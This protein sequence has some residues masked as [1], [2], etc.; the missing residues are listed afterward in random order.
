MGISTVEVLVAG[1]IGIII[2]MS[3]IDM[4][5]TNMRMAKQSEVLSG[6][7]QDQ[8][9]LDG[10]ISGND[11]CT[12]TLGGV[13]IAALNAKD[14]KDPTKFK[15]D[16]IE[17]NS[18]KDATGKE[19]ICKHDSADPKNC[20][21][22]PGYVYEKLLL[23]HGRDP[24]DPSKQTAD[25]VLE[26]QL[27]PND[28]K[29]I[30]PRGRQYIISANADATGKVVS[31]QFQRSKELDAY[32]QS[33]TQAVTSTVRAQAMKESCESMGGALDANKGVCMYN[34]KPISE[35]LALASKDNTQT[36]QALTDAIS[37]VDATA[38]NA[39]A[40][41]Q[42]NSGKTVDLPPKYTAGSCKASC[43][44]P[45][46]VCTFGNHGQVGM[47][48]NGTQTCI[49]NLSLGEGVIVAD[50]TTTALSGEC[51]LDVNVAKVSADPRVREG[52][53]CGMVTERKTCVAKCT[54]VVENICVSN[55][56][57]K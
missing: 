56:P 22:M 48:N 52:F 31:C 29:M 50:A 1:S 8:M 39:L 46:T 25:I 51:K 7:K 49:V 15:D 36:V 38:T 32:A 26:L 18:L 20:S 44:I 30:R 17:V 23:K 42:A 34:G 43:T 6:I 33:I 10:I 12:N 21:K 37:K 16:P 14:P 54:N 41:A 11:A 2:A 13:D 57:P 24:N 5:L 45:V 35:T 9:I 53:S 3:T 27:R 47:R 28:T 55:C 19:I 40:I 4:T